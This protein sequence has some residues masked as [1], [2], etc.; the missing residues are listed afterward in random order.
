LDDTTKV[1]TRFRG[2]PGRRYEFRVTAVDRAGNRSSATGEDL[3]IPVDDRDRSLIRFSKGWRRLKRKGAWG[4][5]VVRST[6]RGATAKLR[7]R[8]TRVALIGRRLPR[9]GRL[10]VKIDRR[11]RTVRLRGT[12]RH[13]RVLFTSRRL[14]SGVHG[15]RVTAVGGGPVELDAVGVRP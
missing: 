14:R 15:V 13:R 2:R 11:T 1:S 10:R 5:H 4:R 3:L 8:G 9:G 7:F 12:P 6:R